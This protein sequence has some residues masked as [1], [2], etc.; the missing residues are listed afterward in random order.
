MKARDTDPKK[1]VNKTVISMCFRELAS[2]GRRRRIPALWFSTGLVLVLSLVCGAQSGKVENL[3]PLTDSGVS[4]A[5]RQTLDSKGY[6]VFLDDGK[7]FCELWLRKAVPS[8]AKKDVPSVAYPQL[9]ESTLIGVLHFLQAATDY[10]GEAIPV[11][12]YTLRY[13][14]LPNDG[15]HL[16]VAPNL[17]FLL[18]NSGSVRPRS[19]Y[20]FQDPGTRGAQSKINRNEASGPLEHGSIVQ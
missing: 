7:P 4:Q 11:G 9:A 6:R 20:C 1:S 15:N 19:R 8:Q 18:L 10:R 5:A 12:F 3:G 16:G 14:L 2:S 13:A 17:D